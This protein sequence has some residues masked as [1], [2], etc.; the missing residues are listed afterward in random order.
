[1]AITSNIEYIDS[2]LNLE[3]GCDGCEVGAD[4]Y[5]NKL[6]SRTAGNSGIPDKF[7]HPV[8]YPERVK[9]ASKWSD[10][11][12]TKRDGKEWLNGYPRVIFLNDM[13]D[14]FTRSLSRDWIWPYFEQLGNTP[15]I[16]LLLTKYSSLMKKSLDEYCILS[17]PYGKPRTLPKNFIFGVSVTGRNTTGRLDVLREISHQLNPWRTW[18]SF[19]PVLSAITLPDVSWLDWAVVGGIS[20]SRLKSSYSQILHLVMELQNQG[21]PTFFK[22]WGTKEINPYQDDHTIGDVKGG[23]KILSGYLNRMFPLE[24]YESNK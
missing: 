1:M 11:T 12:G 17:Q 5:A 8:I 22:Q 20:N 9:L 6:V 24:L 14:T 18:V 19:E 10:L 16:Y 23:R 3:I 15:H 2:S 4:C 21:V 13:G 7:D